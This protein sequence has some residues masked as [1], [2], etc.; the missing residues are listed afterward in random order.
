MKYTA[1]FTL[2]IPME[3][4]RM[5]AIPLVEKITLH[6]AIKNEL[7]QC[8]MGIIDGAWGGNAIDWKKI[9]FV[10]LFKQGIIKQID[11]GKD[12]YGDFNTENIK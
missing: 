3:E 10:N 1:K 9:L 12:V 8:S 6:K 7:Y 4:F 5:Y 11:F 2:S